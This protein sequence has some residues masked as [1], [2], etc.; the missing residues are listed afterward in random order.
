M[1]QLRSSYETADQATGVPAYRRRGRTDD[2]DRRLRCCGRTKMGTAYQYWFKLKQLS[3][4]LQPGI[5][6]FMFYLDWSRPR[7]GLVP[8]FARLWTY[9]NSCEES[10]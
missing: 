9:N 1:R 2:E 7:S 6:E 10:E 4:I 8:R 5:T 3:L